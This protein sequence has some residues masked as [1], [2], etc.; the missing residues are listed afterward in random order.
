MKNAVGFDNSN[1]VN[2]WNMVA[3]YYD[4]LYKLMNIYYEASL[5]SGIG[6]DIEAFKRIVDHT[7]CKYTHTP[8]RLKKIR[9][10]WSETEGKTLFVDWVDKKLQN[11]ENMSNKHLNRQV[12]NPGKQMSTTTNDLIEQSRARHELRMLYRS[13]LQMLQIIGAFDKERKINRP[14]DLFKH[15]SIIDE[16]GEDDI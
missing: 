6:D 10:Y 14:S 12:N 9:Q 7:E 11:V 15:K 16:A 4:Q 3:G 2:E 8:D 1:V 5:T 13:V